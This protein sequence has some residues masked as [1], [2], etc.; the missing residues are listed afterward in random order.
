MALLCS[1]LEQD[2]Y[3]TRTIEILRK[4]AVYFIKCHLG[5]ELAVE[6]C[7]L[8]HCEQGIGMEE[9]V[10]ASLHKE[11]AGQLGSALCLHLAER[12]ENLCTY[13]LI[14][15][16]REAMSQR[17]IEHIHEHLHASL[18]VVALETDRG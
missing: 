2:G 17:L 10:H 7:C 4:A 1:A 12:H 9:M 3:T 14:L 5:K 6:L 16:G 15:L 11:V 8:L 18:P 13:T